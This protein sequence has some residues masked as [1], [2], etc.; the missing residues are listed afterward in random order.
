MLVFDHEKTNAVPNSVLSGAAKS[1]SL[2]RHAAW[3]VTVLFLSGVI[4]SAQVE[5]GQVAGTVTDQS[6][7]VVP[8]ADVV[9]RNVGTNATRTTQT[10]GTGFY[11][12]SGLEPATY[13]ITVRSSSFKSFTAKVEVTVGGRVTMDAHLS[14]NTSVTEVQV[15]AEGGAQVNTQ[16]Q[17]LS[18]V[19]D[20]QQL[21]QLPSLTRNPYDFVAI[22]GNISTGMLDLRAAAAWDRIRRIRAPAESGSTSTVS[23][24]AAPRSFSMAWRTFP[25]LATG[26]EPLFLWTRSR[27]TA[28]RRATSRPSLA[29]LRA[30]SST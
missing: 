4:A 7:A 27:S 9:A 15:V 17:E 26:S 18:Q 1:R 14:I 25:F 24:P 12:L 5:T 6:G 16:T 11:Q 29:G 19:I 3:F 10:S 2:W 28:F 30:A 23:A 8:N 13:E 22:S 21:Q 20:S